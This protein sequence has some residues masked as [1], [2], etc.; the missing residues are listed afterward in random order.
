MPTPG[1]FP[2][3]RG[4]S[5]LSMVFQ[6]RRWTRHGVNRR[7]DTGQPRQVTLATRTQ[8]LRRADAPPPAC[9]P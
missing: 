1:A 9:K 2:S 3:R 4:R 8:H 6:P 5:I 7:I